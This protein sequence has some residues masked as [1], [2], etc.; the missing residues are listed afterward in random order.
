MTYTLLLL[1]IIFAWTNRMFGSDKPLLPRWGSMLVQGASIGIVTTLLHKV[2]LPFHIVTPLLLIVTS[3]L[4]FCGCYLVRVFGKGRWFPHA[5]DTSQ[6]R[7]R[8]SPIVDTITAK[9]E[10]EYT[11]DCTPEFAIKYKTLATGVAWSVCSALKYAILAVLLHNPMA[12]LGIPA[13]LFIGDIYKYCFKW[14]PNEY[15]GKYVVVQMATPITP[16]IMER[17]GD[18]LVKDRE[19]PYS[20]YATGFFI[21]LVDAGIIAVS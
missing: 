9:I 1:P 18:V 4:M 3:I 19:I 12:L 7:E 16:Q 14:F 17:V 13:M 11:S 6:E 10:G 2:S 5:L 8:L 15:G 21:G 20:E